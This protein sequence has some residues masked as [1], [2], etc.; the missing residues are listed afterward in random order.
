MQILFCSLELS[1]FLPAP[2][3][4]ICIKQIAR[5]SCLR[6]PI[7]ATIH[8]DP[9]TSWREEGSFGLHLHVHSALK[10]VIART[11]NRNLEL[12]ADVEAMEQGCLL[13][14]SFWLAQPVFL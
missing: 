6:L 1:C 8:H 10:E 3:A 13:A 14:D 11:Q 2:S 4:K 9:K 7:A 12:G 5:I